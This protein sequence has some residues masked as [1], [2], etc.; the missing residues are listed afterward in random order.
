MSPSQLFRGEL[1][2]TSRTLVLVAALLLIPSAFLPVWNITLVA[3]QYPQGLSL[4][5]YAN[6]VAGE[7]QEVNIL[8]HYIGM[9][10][11]EQD[12]FPEFRFI[13]FLIL[14][15]LA[16]AVLAAIVARLEIG[17]LGWID[18]LVF[19]LVMLFDFQHWLY[20][21][22]HN[23]SPGAPISLDPF[24]PKF[25]GTTQVA[26]FTVKSWPA[27]GAVM[28]ALAGL[29]GPVALFFEWRRRKDHAAL[30]QQAQV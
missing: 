16:L 4:A 17:A 6:K 2:R 27:A 26:N 19:G 10:E 13:P 23:L 3:P 5:I 1:S 28:M 15:F 18:F 8:N 20:E 30:D 24:T 12:E 29:L 9:K 25:I 7:I 14:R 21:Y 11:I 22:G